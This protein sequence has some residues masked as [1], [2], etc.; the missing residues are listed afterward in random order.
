MATRFIACF[1]IPSKAAIIVLEKPTYIVL[2]KYLPTSLTNVSLKVFPSQGIMGDCS[3]TARLVGYSSLAPFMPKDKLVSNC[4]S[5]LI[6]RWIGK[7]VE[8]KTKCTVAMRCSTLLKLMAKHEES[9]HATW[10]LVRSNV[11][12]HMLLWLLLG[13]MEIFF[14]CQPMPWEAT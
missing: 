11:M 14:I 6:R 7:S 8:V 4:C 5:E 3:T 10:L 2:Q 1:T 9:S 13:V 12:Q